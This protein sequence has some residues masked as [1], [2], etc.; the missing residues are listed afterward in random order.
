MVLLDLFYKLNLNFEVAHC[1]FQLRKDDSILDEELVT[2]A[3]DNLNIKL[4]T[5]QFYFSKGERSKSIQNIAREKRYTWFNE[6]L[7]INNLDYIVTAHHANDNIETSL[8]RFAQGCGLKGLIGIAP[9]AENKLRPLL[10]FSK[11]KILAYAKSK[12]ITWREDSSNADNKYT[13]NLI[14]N[15]VIPKLEKINPNIAASFEITS[16]RLSL[17]EKI[18]AER[19]KQL[20][21]K[22]LIKEREFISIQKSAFFE[23]IFSDVLFYELI[24]DFKFNYRTCESIFKQI[25]KTGIEFENDGR[26][27]LLRLERENLIIKPNI[28]SETY[29]KEIKAIEQEISLSNSEL[30]F[31][32]IEN[33]PQ[34]RFTNDPTLAF[35]DLEKLSDKLVVKTPLIG[36]YF[37]PFGMNGKQKISD[38]CI[39][40]KFSKLEKQ[41][42][43]VLLSNG[44]IIW[45]IGRRASN[46][47]RVSSSTKR[48][49][50][51][52]VKKIV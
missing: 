28:N 34:L 51:C 12:S 15:E 46:L 42:V 1:N 52:H 32:I 18:L 7:K 23:D 48:I 47:C 5:K 24:S 40:N 37:I 49:L 43:L 20:K 38:F 19:L 13:R 6:L 21:E 3:C 22:H 39:N 41:K 4:H 11:K 10:S 14:R 44:K 50:E 17:A 36:D 25:N 16:K 29:F 27:Y 31:R 8:F 33:T 9:I 30:S 26:D 35:F 2:K 45:V